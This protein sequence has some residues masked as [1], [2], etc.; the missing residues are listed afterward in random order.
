MTL[1]TVAGASGLVGSTITAEALARGYT[2]RGTLRDATD[3]AKR[4]SLMSL[5]GAKER[6][7]LV[8]ADTSDPASFDAACEGADAIFVA[9]F[10]PIYKAADGTPATQLDRQRGWDEIVAPVVDGCRT[11]LQ[12]AARQ[13][14][15]TVLLC[16]STSSTNPPEPVEVK[17][18][19]N[20]VSSGEQQM[21]AGK[22]TSAEKIYMEEMAQ[23]LCDEAGMRLC[24]FLPTMM[25]GPVL[26]H[27]QGNESLGLVRGMIEGRPQHERIPT[28]SISA[29]HVGDVA[30]LFLAGYEQPEARGRYFAVRDSWPVADFYAELGRLLPDAPQPL[31]PEGEIEAPTRFDFTRQRSLGVTMRDI[32]EVLAE[33]VAF[34]RGKQG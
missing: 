29:A 25:L 32:P 3:T 17:T 18:E 28:G 27:L 26:P 14:V 9:C 22:Y 10:P 31:P 8:S 20:A 16:S 12:A 24:I 6:L 2:V 30:K 11:V 7:T 19:D 21:A 4:D 23:A 34:L 33:T 1:L 13:G 15:G 5:P